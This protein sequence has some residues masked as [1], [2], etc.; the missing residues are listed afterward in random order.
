[1][2]LNG[3]AGGGSL[4]QFSVRPFWPAG[5]LM[6]ALHI[7]TFSARSALFLLL[8]PLNYALEFGFFLL[9]AI[10]KLM[11]LRRA[12]QWTDYDL[13]C[14]AIAGPSLLLCT[15]LRSGVISH[16]DFGWRGLLI[17]QFVL[18]L[19]GAEIVHA[20]WFERAR[21]SAF[22]RWRPALALCMIAGCGASVYAVAINRLYFPLA[23]AGIVPPYY[24]PDREIGKRTAAMRAMYERLRTILDQKAVMQVNPDRPEGDFCFQL[25]ARR[26]L[27]AAGLNCGTEF[28]GDPDACADA[29][30]ALISMFQRDS[31]LT[32]IDVEGICRKLGIDALVVAD[33]DP[34]WK[35]ANSWVW[36]AE[37]VVE[38]RYGRA[39][40][41]SASR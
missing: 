29:R 18:L 33:T 38:N 26:Q 40:Q 36:Q 5:V 37:A 15:F 14:L 39:F 11:Q 35:Q 12:R 16:N 25:Y 19:W 10:I 9:I 41:W 6:P 20:L 17:A 32:R 22:R 23:D 1:M 21:P 30:P 7:Q 13:A 34:V 2:S 28:G 4:L 27:A 31:G 3:P 8:L 24:S